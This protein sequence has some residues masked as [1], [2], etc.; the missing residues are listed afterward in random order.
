MGTTAFDRMTPTALTLPS[1]AGK[2]VGGLG[3]N[4][5]TAFSRYR[6]AIDAEMR[7]VVGAEDSLLYRMIRYHVGWEDAEG[8]PSPSA[9]GKTLRPVLCL[10]AYEGTRPHPPR[11]P[12]SRGERGEMAPSPDPSP[13]RVGEPRARQN[14]QLMAPPSPLVGEGGRGGEGPSPAL[15]AAAAIELIH[16]F[17]LVH[18]DIQD[19]DTERHHRATAWSI[20]GVPQA[21]NAGDGLW[22]LATRAFLRTAE[23]GVPAQLVLR[24][25]QRLNDACLTMIEGQS[26]DLSF[27]HRP[28]QAPEYLDMIGRK[29]G[30]LIAASLAIGALL[31]SGDDAA[32]DAFHRFGERLGRVF[33]IQ[34]D[35]LGIWGREQLTGKSASSDIRR[36]KQS[37]PVVYTLS[38]GPS[39]ARAALAEVYALPQIDDE[40]VAHAVSALEEAGAR[41]HAA[42]LA[43]EAHVQALDVLAELTVTEAARDDLRVIAGYLLHRE[44]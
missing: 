39:A 12:L 3:V 15:P 28:V 7:A 11:P 21:I 27:E 43:A 31:G 9:G 34:D 32:A 24:A 22:A 26:L 36:R 16:N 37:Y 10:L 14:P 29:T 30:A 20:W 42:A 23:R 4:L 41:E 17:S 18:D 33:Q 1:L 2:G 5:P 35:I 13:H 8:R 44:Y 25:Q 38:S 40:A 6:D 19:Q